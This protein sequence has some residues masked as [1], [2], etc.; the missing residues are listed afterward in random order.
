MNGVAEAVPPNGVDSSTGLLGRA[1]PVLAAILAAAL[2][3]AAPSRAQ[4]GEATCEVPD[5]VVLRGSAG[6]F[7]FTRD[8]GHSAPLVLEELGLWTKAIWTLRAFAPGLARDEVGIHL[9]SSDDAQFLADYDDI[10]QVRI[11]R[12]FVACEG[13]RGYTVAPARVSRGDDGDGTGPGSAPEAAT[14]FLGLTIAPQG[15]KP[16]ATLKGQLSVF[17]A[18]RAIH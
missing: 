3:C 2:L 6:T 11:V 15:T 1:L 13:A 9:Y 18:A 8:D 4:D 14:A 17:D 12:F 10:D 16:K 5:N 7:I